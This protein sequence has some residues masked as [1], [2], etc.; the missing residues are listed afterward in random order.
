MA[1]IES[2][3]MVKTPTLDSKEF[4][5]HKPW[6]EVDVESMLQEKKQLSD[7]C[8]GITCFGQG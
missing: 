7:T 6:A 3:R 1:V 8:S 4:R 5:D 2:L